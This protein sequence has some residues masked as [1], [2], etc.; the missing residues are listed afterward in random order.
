MSIQK[1]LKTA[2]HL[3]LF[4]KNI[5]N[6]VSGSL[7][8]HSFTILVISFHS[9]CPIRLNDLFA[10]GRLFNLGIFL[11]QWSRTLP[12]PYAFDRSLMIYKIVSRLCPQCLY[13]TVQR[14]PQHSNSSTCYFNSLQ[15]PKHNLEYPKHGLCCTVLVN[16]NEVL[17]S[18]RK[19]TTSNQ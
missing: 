3:K 7:S 9:S 12:S 1:L 6:F 8:A 2:V 19:R 16:L 14:K 4:E 5:F 17:T 15:F 18:T 13:N 11:Y 10:K